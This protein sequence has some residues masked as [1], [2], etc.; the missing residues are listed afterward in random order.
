M[1]ASST[2]SS[3]P[4]AAQSLSKSQELLRGDSIPCLVVPTEL[5]FPDVSSSSSSS[6]AA[7]NQLLTLYNPYSISFRFKVLST[8][9]ASY[10]VQPTT[11]TIPPNSSLQ[12]LVR[13]RFPKHTTHM[14]DK[15]EKRK[16]KFMIEL[17][18]EQNNTLRGSTIIPVKYVDSAAIHNNHQ[19]NHSYSHTASG[20]HSFGNSI[21]SS[22][23]LHH[24]STTSAF[25]ASKG[26]PAAN[27]SSL[28]FKTNE[29]A[30]TSTIL[31]AAI[32]R[33]LPLF[34]GVVLIGLLQHGFVLVETNHDA[35]MWISFSIG[36]MTMLLQMK[37]LELS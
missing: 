25:P 7:S 16:D 2:G 26:R 14:E 4:P 20:F 19:S 9:P 37:M 32:F 30:S 23:A 17:Y 11:G 6:S 24:P 21:P 34:L 12:L 13:R 36:L 10:S 33:M 3:W 31:L 27:T 1:A 5:H 15:K 8:A 28:F 35:K 22:N 29:A 18:D